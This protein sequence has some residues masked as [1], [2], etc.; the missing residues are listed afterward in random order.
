MHSHHKYDKKEIKGVIHR[1]ISFNDKNKQVRFVIYD[2]KLK[3]SDLIITDNTWQQDGSLH[4]VYKYEF[5]WILW[6]P[7]PILLIK[8]QWI[9]TLGTYILSIY[10][11]SFLYTLLS[12]RL[13]SHL[14]KPKHIL[15]RTSWTAKMQLW[16]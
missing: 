10:I 14:P 16:I 11:Y 12:G 2:E 9:L 6:M 13:K 8:K 3:I 15:T 5:L 7:S 4:P 1:N